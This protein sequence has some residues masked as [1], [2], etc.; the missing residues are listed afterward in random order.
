MTDLQKTMSQLLETKNYPDLTKDLIR[1]IVDDI[2]G[3]FNTIA[4]DAVLHARGIRRISDIKEYTPQVVLDYANICLEDGLLTDA[5]IK[6]MTLLKLFLGIQEGDFYRNHLQKEVKAILTKQLELLYA[7]GIITKD[8]ALLQSDMQG[9]FGL[10]YA[11]Y[12]EIVNS[13]ANK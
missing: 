3:R 6:Q 11:E 7:D 5:E 9:L 10:N 1:V 8:E 4:R 13:V 12:E 2:D